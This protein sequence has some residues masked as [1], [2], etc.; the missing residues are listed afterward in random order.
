MLYQLNIVYVCKERWQ[1]IK[2]LAG[3]RH[4]RHAKQSTEREVE[5]TSMFVYYFFTDIFRVLNKHYKNIEY[6]F[7][8]NN[9]DLISSCDK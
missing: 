7:S 6:N 2:L 3:H 1:Q 4:A 9:A 5:T 8:R